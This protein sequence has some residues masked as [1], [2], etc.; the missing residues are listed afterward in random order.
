MRLFCDTADLGEIERALSNP[1]ITGFTT[2]PTL[3][4]KAG[5]EDYAR[6]IEESLEL[7]SRLRPGIEETDASFEVLDY[8]RM[9]DDATVI[10]AVASKYPACR[11]YVKVP[12]ADHRRASASNCDAIR[13]IKSAAHFRINVTAVVSPSNLEDA[14]TVADYHDIVSVFAG[15]IA[16]CGYDAAQVVADAVEAS[17]LGGRARILWASAREPYN[18][19]EAQ[20]AGA[21]IITMSPA[22]IDKLLQ[23]EGQDLDVLGRRTAAQFFDD[24]ARS[25]LRLREYQG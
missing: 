20:D 10:D 23:S 19:Y 11:V 24:A 6:F 2:N 5:V 15:R 4:A 7:A 9:V 13:S 1:R 25:G 22:L 8:D 21:D 16:D 17:E 18:Y 12:I 14:L 3:L